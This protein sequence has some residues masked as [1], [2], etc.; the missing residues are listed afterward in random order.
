MRQENSVFLYQI[1]LPLSFGERL[2]LEFKIKAISQI[3]NIL[4]PIMLRDIFN[5]KQHNNTDSKY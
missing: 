4:K 2:D 1:T 5:V 3:N